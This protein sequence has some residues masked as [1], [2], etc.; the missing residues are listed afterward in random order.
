MTIWTA[1]PFNLAAGA[2]NIPNPAT[3]RDALTGALFEN[4]SQYLLQV[5]ADSQFV[6]PFS[7]KWID[8]PQLNPSNQTV[9]ASVFGGQPIASSGQVLTVTFYGLDEA[10]PE[11][12]PF[13][14]DPVTVAD[15]LAQIGLPNVFVNPKIVDVTLTALHQTDTQTVS[16]YASLI[17]QLGT[18][19]SPVQYD[20]HEESPFDPAGLT[21][22][23]VL[24]NID[25]GAGFTPTW[26]IPVVGASV[27]FSILG[28]GNQ[29]L[30]LYGS[31]RQVP[32]PMLLNN[33]LLPRKLAFSG[34]AT[35]GLQSQ[36]VSADANPWA[37]TTFNR[38]CFARCAVGAIGGSIGYRY[39]DAGGTVRS[40][41]LALSLAAN[42][43]AFV[44]FGH[45]LTVCQWFGQPTTTGSTAFTV[46]I[47]Q[48]SQ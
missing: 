39:L 12:S 31:N 13:A 48:A 42:T 23:D 6:Q 18:G 33:G 19:T 8:G 3:S 44:T 25:G 47:S 41:T 29:R 15:A 32:A 9:V 40:N 10:R 21:V 34:A 26:V 37:N 36:L 43:S 30:V 2:L 20:M 17:V 45:P 28:G 5:G 4:N 38:A 46:D 22:S 7:S 1:G 16:Q 11:I 35:I 24:S 14:A 27:K